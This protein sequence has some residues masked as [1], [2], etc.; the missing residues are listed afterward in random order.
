MRAFN[1]M[2]T[3]L[4]RLPL[5]SKSPRGHYAVFIFFKVF[6]ALKLR[7]FVPLF[8]FILLLHLSVGLIEQNLGR[9]FIPPHII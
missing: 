6:I 9:R 7:T 3:S 8:W 2:A 1:S 5:L 4:E